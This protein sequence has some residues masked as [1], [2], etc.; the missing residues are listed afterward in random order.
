M[1]NIIKKIMLPVMV[2]Y[3]MT[4]FAW[5]QEFE[6]ELTEQPFGEYLAGRHA[7][8]D[9][10]YE[11]SADNFRK[12][13]ELDPENI[14]LNQFSLS[15]FIAAGRYDDALMVSN[16]L[17]SIDEENDLSRLVNFFDQVKNDEFENALANLETFSGSGILNLTKPFFQAWIYAEQGK[18]ELIDQKMLDFEEDNTFNFF[19]YF[20]G[21]MIYEYLGD[22]EKAESY[23]L[24]GLN[25]KGLVNLRGAEAYASI[26]RRTDK[27]D[28]AI[29]VYNR[30]IAEAP[31]NENLKAA[32]QDTL[33]DKRA[34]PFV[35]T[36]E[37]GYAELFYTVAT[38]LMQDNVKGVA[39]NFLQYALIFKTDL[40]LAHFM[41]AQIFE[42]DENYDGAEK[43]LSMIKNN[44]PLYFQAKL[45]RAWLFDEID[46]SDETLEVLQRM[47]KEYPNNREVMNSIAEFYRMHERY[48]EAAISYTKIID[49]IKEPSGRDWLIY[50]TRGIVLDQEKRWVEAERDFK[51][52]L[53]IRPEH[54]QVLNYLAYSWVDQ[55]KNYD[56]AKKMLLRAVE[57]RPNDGYIIDSLGWALFKMGDDEEAVGVLERAAQLQTLD[58]AINDHLG[59][60]YWIAG[61]ENEARFQWRH[62]LSLSPDE[63]KIDIIKSKIKDGYIKPKF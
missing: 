22:L 29:L 24:K 12:V 30:F 41:Q 61:R 34:A 1:I 37:E 57:L 13:L 46:R 15:V 6:T 38:I 8:A 60:A 31:N 4:G 55:G 56:E 50:Y 35:T 27:N 40:P 21:A 14:E 49:N 36:L 16:R 2:V 58:W 23:Y 9:H 63:D 48:K 19:N 7:F 32:L 42:D 33:D 17:R 5:A 11:V 59:D 3:S 47:D 20:L 28:E 62:A 25:S 10:Q 39:S 43:H 44:S 52:A 51:K 53:E 54:P 26:L 18:I 45:Q